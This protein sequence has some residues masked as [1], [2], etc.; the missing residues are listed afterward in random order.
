MRVHGDIIFMPDAPSLFV[1]VV[2]AD[3]LVG[4]EDLVRGKH[5][6]LFISSGD[7]HTA[8]LYGARA[9]SIITNFNRMYVDKYM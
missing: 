3:R 2:G 8:F 1:Q 5:A 4:S 6:T 9:P 7:L